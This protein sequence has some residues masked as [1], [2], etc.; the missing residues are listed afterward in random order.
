MEN[1]S[2]DIFEDEEV[3]RTRES[4]ILICYITINLLCSRNI[5]NFLS[6]LSS[7]MGRS[8]KFPPFLHISNFWKFFLQEMCTEEKSVYCY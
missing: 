1:V 7:E 6:I 8:S 2:T 5:V 4:L 3:F